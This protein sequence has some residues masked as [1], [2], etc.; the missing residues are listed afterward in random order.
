MASAIP[1]SE[2]AAY[3]QAD[4]KSETLRIPAGQPVVVDGV[5]GDADWKRSAKAVIDAGPDWKILVRGKHDAKNLYLVFTGVKHG[6]QRL[7]PEVL[8]DTTSRRPRKWERGVFWFHLSNNLCEGD[9][10][11]DVY[12]RNG[13]FQCA[14]TKPGWDG[15]NSPAKDSDVVEVR[16][17][18]D[19]LRIAYHSGL[20]LG[21]SLEVTNASGDAS[22]TW[23][24]WLRSATLNDP[25]TWALVVLE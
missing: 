9:G 17:S 2:A 19:K 12:Q 13:V 6:E 5:L 21:L 22:Q 7:F 11:H 16:I 23:S 25:S 1:V 14:H 20:K 24:F 10:E 4:S 15:N 8:V 18:F 3:G